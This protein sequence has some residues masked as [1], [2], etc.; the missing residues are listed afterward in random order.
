M[1]IKG[2]PSKPNIKPSQKDTVNDNMKACKEERE[3]KPHKKSSKKD[4]S[5]LLLRVHWITYKGYYD[6]GFK[7]IM[8]LI[9]RLYKKVASGGFKFF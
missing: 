8:G 9:N 3:K 6:D 1:G 4:M 2:E 5:L 7:K